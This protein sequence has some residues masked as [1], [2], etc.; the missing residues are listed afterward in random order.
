MASSINPEGFQLIGPSDIWSFLRTPLIS[1]K[2]KCRAMI[3]PW[4]KKR[5][6]DEESLQSFVTR[7]FGKELFEKLAQPLASG[8]YGADPS[9]LSMHASLPRFVELERR[10]GS[11]SRGLMAAK[12]AKKKQGG[13]A[14]YGMFSAFK[15]GMQTLI[16][17]LMSELG[18]SVKCNTSVTRIT[19]SDEGFSIKLGD[20]QSITTQ[21]V[22]LAVPAHVAA[23]LVAELAPEAS[24]AFSQIQYGSAAVLSMAFDGDA[25]E[26]KLDAFG[27]V[28]PEKEKSP[29]MAATFSHIKYPGRAPA[30]KALMRCYFG[31]PN[32]AH[33]EQTDDVL[34]EQGLHELDRMLGL[35][36]KPHWYIL[37]RYHKA[38]PR[39]TLGHFERV[40]KIEKAL[41]PYPRLQVAGNALYGVG[42]PQV[43]KRAKITANTL[44][45]QLGQSA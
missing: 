15:G 17:A 10:Y 28:V 3:E 30:S 9:T 26:R 14:R 13:G 25:F 39:Y 2:G 27:V 16:D 35:H 18:Q 1:W 20:G 43:V 38:L 33:D 22:V 44:A 45:E 5:L 31:G 19:A 42:I 7:R 24:A 21:A 41:A 40:Q 36:K 6:S 32:A 8:I 37:D 29:I 34:F 11:V 4:V 23:M 12:H